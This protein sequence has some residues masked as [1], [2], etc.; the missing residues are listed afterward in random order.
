[1]SKYIDAE[2]IPWTDLNNGI[3]GVNVY[4]TFLEKVA[5]MPA[6]DVAEVW[7]GRWEHVEPAPYNLFYAT[8][9]VC[10]ER[11]TIEVANYCPM[12]GASMR[13]VNK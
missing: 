1:M 10:G 2:K 4:V 6:A 8:C 7:H 5:R 13:E 11:Q 3:G 9:S 12:C